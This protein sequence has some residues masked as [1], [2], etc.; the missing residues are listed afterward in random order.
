MSLTCKKHDIK[1]GTGLL[2][3][4]V[5]KR[6][7]RF[8]GIPNLLTTNVDSL[9]SICFG[10]SGYVNTY[11][12]VVGTPQLYPFP[13]LITSIGEELPHFRASAG[14]TLMVTAVS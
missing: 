14:K 7:V 2:G 8:T 5:V 10:G 9:N 11:S 13:G 4:V 3:E 6:M 1:S 12:L